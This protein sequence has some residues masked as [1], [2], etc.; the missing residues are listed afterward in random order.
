MKLIKYFINFVNNLISWIS[1]EVGLLLGLFIGIDILRCVSKLRVTTFLVVLRA[2]I[3]LFTDLIL[4][5]LPNS[6]FMVSFSITGN[7]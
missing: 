2:E 4:Y 1:F 5:V 7:D 3:M 6:F